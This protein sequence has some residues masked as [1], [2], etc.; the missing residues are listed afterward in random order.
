MN[1]VKREDLEKILSFLYWE[2]TVEKGFLPVERIQDETGLTNT[3]VQGGLKT[4]GYSGLVNYIYH[5]KDIGIEEARI[6]LKGKETAEQ[7]NE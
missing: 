1:N 6:T 2:E 4:L 5:Q 7:L 3:Q